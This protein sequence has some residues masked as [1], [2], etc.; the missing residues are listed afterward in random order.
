MGTKVKEVQQWQVEVMMAT[1]FAGLKQGFVSLFSFK[2]CYSYG[3]KSF[4]SLSKTQAVKKTETQSSHSVANEKTSLKRTETYCERALSVCWLPQQ[5]SLMATGV[6]RTQG[7]WGWRRQMSCWRRLC[8][9]SSVWTGPMFWML[10]SSWVNR[11]P[12]CRCNR[13]LF[14]WIPPVIEVYLM[15]QS[16]ICIM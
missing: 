7:W 11:N 1:L 14:V 2:I 3:I 15:A 4:K 10:T 6:R 12:I 5:P 16:Y 9:E 13:L 8:F